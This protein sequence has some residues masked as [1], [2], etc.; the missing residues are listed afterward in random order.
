MGVGRVADAGVTVI[1]QTPTA[2]ATGHLYLLDLHIVRVRQ[3]VMVAME[4]DTSGQPQ[5]TGSF[6]TDCWRLSGSIKFYDLS[7]YFKI[8]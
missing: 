8:R 1:P 5:L 7:N 4:P 2:V 6:L 3:R